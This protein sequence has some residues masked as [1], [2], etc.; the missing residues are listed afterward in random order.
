VAEAATNAV[1]PNADL[2]INEHRL[3]KTVI[4]RERKG[5]SRMESRGA[6]PRI[7]SPR[8]SRAAGILR[9]LAGFT[10][11]DSILRMSPIAGFV[12]IDV[13]VSAIFQILPGN[14]S[15]SDAGLLLISSREYIL[16]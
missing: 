7:D 16:G 2:L 9:A 14:D 1:N 12:G 11:D 8:A 4:A 5:D 15:G 6:A 10:A 13:S 3:R